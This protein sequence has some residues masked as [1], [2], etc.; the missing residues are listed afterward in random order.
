MPST[1]SPRA[2]RPAGVPALLLALLVVGLLLV[3]VAGWLVLLAFDDGWTRL[4]WAVVG[5]LLFWQLLP[6]P[7]RVPRRAVR[8]TPAEAPGLDGLAGAVAAAVGARAP[9]A[10]FVDTTYEVH[11]LPTGYLG[12]AAL[13]VGLPQ[14][15]ALDPGE[16]VAALAHELSCAEVRRRPAGVLV[17]LA[18][19]VL[20]SA[21][22]VLRPTASRSGENARGVLQSIGDLGALGVGADLAGKQAVRGGTDAVGAAGMTVVAAPVRAVQALLA[23]LWLPVLRYAA[24]EADARA[25][26][27]AGAPA[28]RGWLLSTTG[29]PRGLTAANNAARTPGADPFTAMESAPRPEAA[30]LVRRLEGEPAWSRDLEHPPT[31]ERLQALDRPV[32][33]ASAGGIERSAVAAADAEVFRV[34]SGLVA[35][36][37][38]ELVHGR[39]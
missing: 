32:P 12:G 13:V 14:W 37:R 31:L 1:H 36:F 10:V 21:R 35:R 34:R 18:D 33:T 8:M 9:S 2:G 17:R 15:T 25:A 26:A 20:T 39:S 11:V 22:T 27:V 28:V 29:V 38:E 3:L 16:R 4:L 7:R 5:V 19:D 23:R 24:L 30:E 6:R